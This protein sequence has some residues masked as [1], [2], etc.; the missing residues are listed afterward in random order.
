MAN[1]NSIVGQ[2]STQSNSSKSV[3]LKPTLKVTKKQF[4]STSATVLLS[5]LALGSF[6]FTN[7]Y[8]TEDKTQ[9]ALQELSNAS[10]PENPSHFSK[11][12]QRYGDRKL[13]VIK[14]DDTHFDFVL[15]PT[16]DKTAKIIIK[17]IDLSLLV[18][19]VPEWAKQDPGLEAIAITD[20]EWNRQQ[21]SFPVDSEHIEI[22]GGDGFEKEN[23]SSIGLAKNC[24]NA[25]LWEVL[26]FT[27]EDGKKALY[28][29]GWFDFPIG[30]YKDVFEK[31]NNI[32]YWKHWWKL[33]HW[34]DPVGTVTNL[35]LLREVIAQ[36]EVSAEF[37][38][39]E[40]IIVAGEQSRK[41]RT[42]QAKNL[43]TWGDFYKDENQI[44]F[45]TFRPPGFYDFDKPWGNQYWRIGKFEKAVVRNVK[46]VGVED[47][48]QEI[49]LVFS[50]TRTGE[51]N[52]LLFSGINLKEL[53]QLPV[54]EYNKGFYMPM[55]IGVPPF[56]Q[57]YEELKQ[58]PPHESP[59]FSV[60]L[61]SKDQWIDHHS[62]AVDGPVM[63]RDQ[64]NPNLLHVYL[65][66]YERHTLV[67]HFL[68]NLEG[69]I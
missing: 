41:I 51:Q 9:V 22:I 20:R 56:Y 32:S 16:D 30:H 55:G 11:N 29:Q 68:I 28:Y 63:H 12:F 5:V 45:A 15:E 21:V 49:E 18:P 36:Q 38:L 69:V 59:Y 7:R 48:L 58:N 64:D 66:S 24:L 1:G 60:L 65:L 53:P 3:F 35:N 26:L 23:I 17:N 31:I 57:S 34:Q 19:K 67:G 33:E 39:D 37:P 40:K 2:V 61:D 62:L 47:N 25:G 10:Y 14:K 46:P 8:K 54:E 44:E 4:L 42:I 6:G 50:D 43:K 27:K 13:T 52:R